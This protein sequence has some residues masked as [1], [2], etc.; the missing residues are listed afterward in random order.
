MEGMQK[1]FELQSTVTAEMDESKELSGSDI[2]PPNTAPAVHGFTEND[3]RDMHRMGKNQELMRNFRL[4]STVGFTTCVMGTWEILLTAN[5]QGL[6]AGGMAGLFWSLC[7][8]YVGQTFIVLSLAEMASMAPTAGG[9]Y[10]WVSEFAPRKYQKWMSYTSGWLA[11]L[12]WQS[13]VAADCYIV[14]GIVQGLIV[15]ADPNYVPE[16]WQATLLIIASAIGIGLFNI[17]GAKHLPLA[18]G[19]FATFHVFAF[20]PVIAVLWAMAPKQS[21]RAVFVEFTDNGAGWPTTSLAVMVGQVSSMFAV[22]GSDSVAHIS[23]EIED[24]GVIVPRGMMWAFLLNIPLTFGLLL[25]YLFCIGDVTEALGSATG[26]PFIYVFSNATQSRGGTIALVVVVLL[27]LIMITISS[28]AS[29]SRQIWAFSRDRG[30]PFSGWLSHVH[31]SLQIPANSIIFTCLYTI[32]LSLINIGSSVGF[33]AVLSL[34]SSALMATYL[35]SIGSVTYKRLTH[36]PLP[37]ARWSLGRYG[38]L[39]NCLACLYAFWAF[40]W[41]FWPN[42]YQPTVQMFNW[43]SVLFSG[44]MIIAALVYVFWARKVYEGPVA[45]VRW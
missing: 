10:H 19:I 29:S 43:S 16:R 14:G 2:D 20:F 7:W 45:K 12:S 18:E 44:V 38:L 4:I 40:F 37:T 9:Q 31:P 33:N 3:R 35:I 30:L 13:I 28:L 32:L 23:E 6:I 36:Q 41:S 15:V 17:Y 34:T 22:I 1:G 11:T 27:L 24:A 21:A 5:T 39:V 42:S 8:C 25:T 26:Y